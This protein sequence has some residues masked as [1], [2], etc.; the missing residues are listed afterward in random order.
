M[1]G[2]SIFWLLKYENIVSL[3]TGKVLLCSLKCESI[4]FAFGLLDKV[5]NIADAASSFER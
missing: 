2:F 5:L 4:N 3:A 1:S